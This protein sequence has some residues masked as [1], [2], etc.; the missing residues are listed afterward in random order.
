MSNG[1]LPPPPAI[2]RQPDGSPVSCQDK[3]RVLAEN[4]RELCEVMRDAFEDAVL[5][6]VDAQEMKQVIHGIVSA[7]QSPK[8]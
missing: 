6:G 4:Y 1:A 5:I 2:W 8:A 3:L 7:L